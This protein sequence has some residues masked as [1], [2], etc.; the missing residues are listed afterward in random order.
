MQHYF[1]TIVGGNAILNGDQLHHLIDVKRAEIGEMIEV[2]EE[3]ESYLCRVDSIAPLTISVVKH[4]EEKRELDIDLTIAF[5]LLKGDKNEIIVLKGTELGVSTFI[6]FTS[7]RTIVDVSDKKQKKKERLEKIAQEGA[8]QCRRD[9]IPAVKDI[10]TFRDLL[11]L[12]YDV[13]LFAFEGEAGQSNSII[14]EALK[15]QKRSSVLV[16][17]GPEGGFD[18]EEV[19]LASDY[20]FTFVGLGRRILRAETA[21]IYA[22]SIVGALSEE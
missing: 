21:A 18:P 14:K 6:P 11:S 22:A 4:I 15:I 3:G 20:G 19:A 8:K 10:V 7:K 12:N 1:G 9:M 16:V 17:I 5:A 2:S 13:K